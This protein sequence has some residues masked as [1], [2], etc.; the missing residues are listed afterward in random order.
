MNIQTS[1]P[2][3]VTLSSAVTS[4]GNFILGHC[5]VAHKRAQLV[6]N[7]IAFVAT[8]LRANWITGEGAVEHLDSVGLLNF[9]VVERS[10]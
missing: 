2:S 4:F 1:S 10:S 7:E 6:A 3:S 5:V 8:A 9:V